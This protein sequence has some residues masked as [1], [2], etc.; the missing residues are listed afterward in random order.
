VP[1]DVG[2]VV[3]AIRESGMPDADR[4]AAQWQI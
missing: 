3:H 2:A 1:F 4:F